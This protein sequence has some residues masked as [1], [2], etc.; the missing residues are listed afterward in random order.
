MKRELYSTRF[1][2]GASSDAENRT[3]LAQERTDLAAQRTNLAAERTL[4]S[5]WRTGLAFGGA[6]AL[7]IKLTDSP[8]AF[9]GGGTLLL[10]GSGLFLFG[11]WRMTASRRAIT[12]SKD[13]DEEGRLAREVRER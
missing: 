13:S 2:N 5:Y 1:E 4:L 8:A 3:A 10:L 6:G 9:V 11:I 12:K 7:L